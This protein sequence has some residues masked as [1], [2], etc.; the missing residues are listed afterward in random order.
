[1]KHREA[2]RDQRDRAKE[3]R[4][5]SDVS[6]DSPPRGLSP[7]RD[8]PGAGRREQGAPRNDAGLKGV[9]PHE[10]GT[11][12]RQEDRQ[13]VSR[14]GGRQAGDD[15]AQGE[16]RIREVDPLRRR[17][18]AAL[19]A[20]LEMERHGSEGAVRVVIRDQENASAGGDDVPE[21]RRT[22]LELLSG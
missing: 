7:E 3:H 12:A 8:Q 18:L 2:E 10:N 13:I 4:Q 1:S 17:R 9:L 22:G 20:A 15:A 19:P 16:G 11:A 21:L 14:G 5:R 6:R